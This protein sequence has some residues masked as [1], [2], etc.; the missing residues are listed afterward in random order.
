MCAAG[1][2]T[3]HLINI[4]AVVSHRTL[5]IPGS[6]YIHQKIYSLWTCSTFCPRI[7]AAIPQ[8]PRRAMAVMWC[9]F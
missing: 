8:A 6:F 9:D 5:F 3:D 4:C 1:F 2:A 7:H